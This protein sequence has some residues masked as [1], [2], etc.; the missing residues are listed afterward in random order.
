MLPRSDPSLQQPLSLAS[1]PEGD[2]NEGPSRGTS[3][4]FMVLFLGARPSAGDRSQGR[5]TGRGPPKG[6]E[7]SSGCKVK[8][9][10]TM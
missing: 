5:S 9:F 1:S 3:E 2:S 6:L 10:L 4:S 7:F 8:L